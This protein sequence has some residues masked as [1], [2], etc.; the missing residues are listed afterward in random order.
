MSAQGSRGYSTRFYVS[1][2]IAAEQTQL[3]SYWMWERNIAE[4]SRDVTIN[5]GYIGFRFSVFEVVRVQSP[6]PWLFRAFPLDC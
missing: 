1:C 2:Y 4:D 3:W 6:L 5:G